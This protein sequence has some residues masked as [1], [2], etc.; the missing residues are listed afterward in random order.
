[1]KPTTKTIADSGAS[2]KKQLEDYQA[3]IFISIARALS[4]E[5]SA[6]VKTDN[7]GKFKFKKPY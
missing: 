2:L 5:A 7:Q 3:A 1:L 6:D 4:K